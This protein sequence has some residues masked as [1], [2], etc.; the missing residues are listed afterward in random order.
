MFPW[1]RILIPTDFSTAAK[2]V[3][4]D[5]IRMAKSTKAELLI[6]HVRMTHRSDPSQLRYPAD[7]SVYDYV[8]QHEL[9]LLRKHVERAD[10]TLRTRLIVRK[11]SDP[12]GEILRTALDEQAD[13]IV[14]ATHARHHIAHLIVGSTTLALLSRCTVPLLSIRYGIRKRLA[15]K[16]MILAVDPAR[17]S[18]MAIALAGAI[19]RHEGSKITIACATG[20]ASSPTAAEAV[21]TV[22]EHLEDLDVDE[23]ILEGS[24]DREIVRLAASSD[25]DLTI[26]SP[27]CGPSEEPSDTSIAIIRRA[28]TPVLIVP[29]PMTTPTP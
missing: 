29:E 3:F 2:W 1:R 10:P 14:M 8:E 16:K 19:A 4:D 11:S 9:E 13:L 5:A 15:L 7:T 23:V 27:G 25:A 12:G 21:S 17:P 28:E 20:Q 6:L 26:I 18:Q 22:R 24:A